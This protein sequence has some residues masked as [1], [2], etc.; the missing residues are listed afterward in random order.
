MGCQLLVCQMHRTPDGRFSA[1][2]P[3]PT[4]LQ[5][6]DQALTSAFDPHCGH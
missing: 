4:P 6:A 2:A 1:A 5:W 3:S